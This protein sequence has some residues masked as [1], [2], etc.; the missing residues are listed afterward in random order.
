MFVLKS[1][2]LRQCFF[3][4]KTKKKT[5]RVKKQKTDTGQQEPILGLRPPLPSLDSV[6]LPGR[7][8][9]R[10][11][12]SGSAA[13]C[14][15]FL[16]RNPQSP[17]LSPLSPF[18]QPIQNQPRVRPKINDTDRTE[19]VRVL[20]GS[21][22]VSLHYSTGVSRLAHSS[23]GS[24]A[25]DCEETSDR[26]GNQLLVVFFLHPRLTFEKQA[27]A[28]TRQFYPILLIRAARFA[29]TALVLPSTNRA[30][31]HFP[32]RPPPIAPLRNCR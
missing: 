11:F 31:F 25:A 6:K 15:N 30:A 27:L 12:E 1:Q 32:T 14:L 22:K 28:C 2:T 21:E 9:R 16:F 10:Q 19:G 8:Q 5:G 29:G 26:L 18:S 3:I 24:S 13:N 4:G 17:E 7:S 23:E 20:G